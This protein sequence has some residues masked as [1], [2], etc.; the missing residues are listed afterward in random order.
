MIIEGSWR[1]LGFQMVLLT[2]TAGRRGRPRSWPPWP[3]S[4]RAGRSSPE[5]RTEQCPRQRSC[6]SASLQ[7]QAAESSWKHPVRRA[8]PGEAAS[9]VPLTGHGPVGLPHVLLG[10]DE[11]DEADAAVHQPHQEAGRGENLVAGCQGGEVAEDHLEEQTW[12]Q[13]AGGW[14]G[15][16]A[17]GGVILALYSRFKRIFHL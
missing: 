14:G 9:G 1:M 17:K 10:E 3:E 15:G 12:E 5:H 6:W 2:P 7:R 11:A 16:D 4:S 8:V 13:Q